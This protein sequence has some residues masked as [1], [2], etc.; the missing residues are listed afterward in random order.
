MTMNISHG[1]VK[2]ITDLAHVEAA[3]RLRGCDPTKLDPRFIPF[4]LA[5][6]KGLNEILCIAG[7]QPLRKNGTAA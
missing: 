5:Q 4:W 3:F 6:G 1:D 2:A 7:L